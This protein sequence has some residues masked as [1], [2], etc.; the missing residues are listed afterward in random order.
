MLAKRRLAI[1]LF[2]AAALAIPAVASAASGPKYRQSE[3]LVRFKK[4]QDGPA[5]GAIAKIGAKVI[6]KISRVDVKRLGLPKDLPVEAALEQLRK[7]PVFEFVEPNYIYRP[8]WETSDPHWGDQWALAKI[9]TAAG[10]G[11]ETGDAKVVIAI[12]DTG[13]DL[14]HPDLVRKIVP[15]YD[16]VDGDDQADDVASH[17]THCAGI[18]AASANNGKGIAG[19]CANCS[20]MPV[21]VLNADGGSASDVANGIVWAA[22]HGA[23]VISL[24]LGGIFE[25]ITQN[26]AIDYAWSKGAVVVAAAGNLGVSAPHY[27]GTYPTCIAVGATETDDRRSD[28]SNYGDW[29]D[30]AAP[31]TFI[32]STVPGGY[33]MMSG[34]SMAT[35]HVAGLAGLVWSA[36]GAGASNAAVREV[37]EKSC[38]PVGAW[39]AK[40]RINVRRAMELAAAAGASQGGGSSGSSGASAG[41]GFAPGYHKI[42]QGSALGG[43]LGSLAKSDD[44]LLVARSTQSGKKRYVDVQASFRAGSAASSKALKVALEGR[45]YAADSAVTVYLFDFAAAKWVWIGRV[46]LGVADTKATVKRD[47]PKPYVGPGDEV[48]VKLS[49]ESDWFATFDFGVDELR[50]YSE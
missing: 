41:A 10:W 44:D 13:V 47:N 6:G 38:D 18:A 19:I 48:R 39:V 12:L 29:V 50:L 15:G 9:R 43:K 3:L 1:T 30:V 35:P 32:M 33:G 28:Y 16:F 23:K 42:A 36:M 20:I 49:A 7:L 22:D 45:F 37:I 11:L 31:G 27:P 8:V 4:G 40:G 46:N 21:R 17:G 25:S 24:S 34:T 14:D 5:A 26:E 2:V